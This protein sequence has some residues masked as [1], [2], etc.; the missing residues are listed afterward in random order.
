MEGCFPAIVP[1]NNCF[2]DMGLISSG[3]TGAPGQLDDPAFANAAKPL[4]ADAKNSVEELPLAL[5]SKTP[6]ER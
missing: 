5:T 1:F 2:L 6:D 4:C 3:P